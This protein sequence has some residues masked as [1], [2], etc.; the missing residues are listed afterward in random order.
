MIC[1][2]LKCPHVPID[3]LVTFHCVEEDMKANLTLPVVVK[4]TRAQTLGLK[5]AK[6]I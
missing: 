1:I 6:I 5:R 4:G 3:L 2:P